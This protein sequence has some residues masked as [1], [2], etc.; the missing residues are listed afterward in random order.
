[1]HSTL[2]AFLNS[3]KNLDTLVA[4]DFKNESPL[5]DVRTEK[6]P[7]KKMRQYKN[8]FNA[9]HFDCDSCA[10]S[11]SIY[12]ILWGWSVSNQY[13]LPPNLRNSFPWK[14]FG[15]DTMNSYQTIFNHYQRTFGTPETNPYIRQL[16]AATHSIGNFTLVPYKLNPKDIASFNQFRGQRSL[17]IQGRLITSPYYV[18]DFFDLSLKLI[19]ETVTEN[20]FKEYID[21]FFLN[22]YVDENYAIIPLSLGHETLLKQEKL[23]TNNNYKKFLPATISELNE[24]LQVV[25]DKINLR[26]NRIISTLSKVT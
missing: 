12:E 13:Q 15:C 25:L 11:I 23:D 14:T 24:Y 9:T 26:G 7:I 2:A 1:M 18:C 16:A 22:D 21:T 17:K 3:G 20:T 8:T 5:E 4:Y 19:K 10:L 6:D